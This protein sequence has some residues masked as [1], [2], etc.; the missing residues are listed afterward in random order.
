[1]IKQLTLI[2][3]SL[4][5]IQSVAATVIYK[6][7][8]KDGVAHYSQQQPENINSNK[9]YSEDIEQNPIG[10][11]QP[12][13]REEATPIQSE[14][15]KNAETIKKQSAEQANAICESAKQKLN[16]LTSHSRLKSKNTNT[17][18][19]VSMNEEDRQK[20]IKAQK[21]RIKLFCNT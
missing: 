4:L 3:F 21:E 6:W 2:S 16:I 8:D 5:I 15:E 11:I 1:M 20:H 7:V 17:G 13:I 19:I 9:I 12:K 18:E 10:F 14:D